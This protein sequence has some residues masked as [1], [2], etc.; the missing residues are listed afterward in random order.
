ML[1]SLC[2][3]HAVI[4]NRERFGSFGW[5]Q[6]YQFSTNDLHISIKMLSEVCMKTH[7]GQ[8]FPLK[9]M[10]YLVSDLNYGGKLTNSEDHRILRNQVKSFI[11]MRV[12]ED[13]SATVANRSK[14]ERAMSL[15]DEYIPGQIY[16][17]TGC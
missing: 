1:F 13:T 2:V 8:N 4:N 11:N 3:M 9:L 12:F 10:R 7:P 15:L 16:D 5:T 17:L 6:P 14:Y